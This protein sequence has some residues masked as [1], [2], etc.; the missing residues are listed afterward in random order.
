[1]TY[2]QFLFTAIVLIL[3]FLII[4]AA[5]LQ[6][7][8]AIADEPG[9]VAERRGRLLCRLGRH[10]KCTSPI[11]GVVVDSTGVETVPMGTVSHC[12]RPGCNWLKTRP[13][14]QTS[15]STQ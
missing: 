5:A 15:R 13:A 8:L 4:I 7:I 11:V 12:H 1:M 6:P 9:S 10:Q 3:C 2:E 14:K